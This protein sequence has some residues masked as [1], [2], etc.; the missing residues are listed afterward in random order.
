MEGFPKLGTL[1]LANAIVAVRFRRGGAPEGL[2]GLGN[3]YEC[4]GTLR[5]LALPIEKAG[6]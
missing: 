2:A 4:Q 1:V 5:D 6:R 3:C